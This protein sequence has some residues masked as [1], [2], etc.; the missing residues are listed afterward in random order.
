MQL[1]SGQI[2]TEIIACVSCLKCV[3]SQNDLLKS[4]SLF[5][6]IYL[7]LAQSDRVIKGWGLDW[8]GGDS[9][10]N[11]TLLGKCFSKYKIQKLWKE[12]ASQ[13]TEYKNSGEEV[14]LKI[15]NMPPCSFCSPIDHNPNMCSSE[16]RKLEMTFG[17][18]PPSCYLVS[19][20]HTF[21]KCLSSS[22]VKSPAPP[23]LFGG[24]F[25]FL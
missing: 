8:M 1:H 21:G 10:K 4:F 11:S 20:G 23:L 12:S 7:Y 9:R 18:F 22:S 15:Q 3:C 17:G 6:K 16:Q 25:S 13:N 14:Y 19:A 5:G 2:F 24:E